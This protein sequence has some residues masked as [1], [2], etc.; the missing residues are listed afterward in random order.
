MIHFKIYH[1]NGFNLSFYFAGRKWLR[2][3]T[4]EMEKNSDRYLS[5]FLLPASYITHISYSLAQK[6]DIE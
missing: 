2:K 3:K 6:I 4:L 5:D 1:D